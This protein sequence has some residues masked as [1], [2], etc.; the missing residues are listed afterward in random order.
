[1]KSLK[2]SDK[3]DVR[4]SGQLRP[5]GEGAS[6]GIRARWWKIKDG[7]IAIRRTAGKRDGDR[8]KEEGGKKAARMKIRAR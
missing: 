7:L 2:P 3:L 1:M 4:R 8:V 6:L 5:E